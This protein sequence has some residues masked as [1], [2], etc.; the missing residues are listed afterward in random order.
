MSRR[1][2]L[3]ARLKGKPK[4]FAWDELVRLLEGFGL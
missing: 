4:D 1:D 3:V 2:T